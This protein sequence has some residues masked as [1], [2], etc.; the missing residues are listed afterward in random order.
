[1]NKKIEI[2]N[3]EKILKNKKGITLIAL[4]ITIIILLILAGISISALTHTGIFARANDAKT[5]TAMSQEDE[6]V[7]MAVSSALIEGEGELTTKNL[8]DAFTKSNLN[9]SLTGNGPWTYTGEYGE[10]DIE[11]NGNLTA[12]GKDE[13][14]NDEVVKVMGNYGVTKKEKIVSLIFNNEETNTWKEVNIGQ[15]ITEI[16]TVKKMYQEGSSY[17]V[18]NTKGDVYAWGLNFSGR[19]GIGNM[20]DQESPKKISELSNVEDIYTSNYTRFAKTTTGDVYAWGDNG[21]NQLGIGNED[22][23]YSPVKITNLP[24][25]D[26]IYAEESNTYAIT[27]AHEIYVWGANYSGQLGIGNTENQ[28]APVK[29]TNL[30]NIDEI[31]V[32]RSNAYA[33]TTTGEVYAWGYNNY[34][35][36]GIGNTENQNAPVKITNLTNIDEIY[37]NGSNAYAKTTTGEMYAWGYNNYGQLGIGNTE[38][39]S[40]PVK[41]NTIKNIKYLSGGNS[42]SAITETGE[43][44]VWGN[45]ENGQLGIGSTE[46]QSTPVKRDTVNNVEEMLFLSTEGVDYIK[47]TAG[48]IY[49][50]DGDD[51]ELGIED[52]SGNNKPI[53][54]NNQKITNIYSNKELAG[55][56]NIIWTNDG[57]IY[58]YYYGEPM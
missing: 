1:M 23:Q 24:K 17:Y 45:N 37:A 30:T 34:G 25:V 54:W 52:T 58:R 46:N 44:Y 55:N 21:S 9:G 50:W 20:D 8:Q 43:I 27:T 41:M 26:K 40:T 48:D 33:K 7:K 28:N 49:L 47:T 32:N 15:E 14:T 39:Q 11:K 12:N 3:N 53:S 13:S 2:Q 35:Q 4:V 16:G 19:L 5:K 29:I 36:L 18:I 22:D 51:S 38:N 6:S 10:Y 57:K 56:S 42:I 31:Y